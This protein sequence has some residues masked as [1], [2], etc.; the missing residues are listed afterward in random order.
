M[1]LTQ[2]EILNA[3]KIEINNSQV[4][5]F[6]SDSTIVE[7]V[8]D[9]ETIREQLISRGFLQVK[10]G[11]TLVMLP[12]DEFPADI[13]SLQTADIEELG[14]NVLEKFGH[15]T[16]YA[17]DLIKPKG[18]GKIQ[19]EVE[20]FEIVQLF[21]I[22]SERF[23]HEFKAYKQDFPRISFKEMN[24]M[25]DDNG[26]IMFEEEGWMEMV[27]KRGLE[28]DARVFGWMILLKVFKKWDA[29]KEERKEII[30]K[31]R[32]SFQDLKQHWQEL[33]SRENNK[34]DLDAL[35]VMNLDKM[36]EIKYG[37]LKD[38]LRTDRDHEYYQMESSISPSN[39]NPDSSSFDQLSRGL[40]LLF[41]ILMTYAMYNLDLG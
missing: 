27:Y 3:R 30:E 13:Q 16:R 41:Y 25:M 29:N 8:N 33:L 11:N 10:R 18:R 2:E 20:G 5:I 37:I 7:T 19:K 39:V 36:V 6:Y 1:F 34:Q 23:A 15:V 38:I 21:S 28:E 26:V 12:R 9:T 22:D 35:D 24:E 14:W 17:Q 40:Q 32:K 31:K 4:T